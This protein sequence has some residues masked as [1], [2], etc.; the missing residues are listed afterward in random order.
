M[1]GVAQQQRIDYTAMIRLFKAC[2]Y[3]RRRRR[4]WAILCFANRIF[5]IEFFA[6]ALSSL[7]HQTARPVCVR[8][9]SS[10]LENKS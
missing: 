10:H 6:L 5:E 7:T 2:Y 8:E 4:C 9:C 1:H 3:R